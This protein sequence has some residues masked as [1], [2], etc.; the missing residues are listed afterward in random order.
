M[1][2]SAFPTLTTAP[3]ESN[4][5]QKRMESRSRKELL[6]TLLKDAA[7]ADIVQADEVGEAPQNAEVVIDEKDEKILHLEAEM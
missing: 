5:R 1:L 4:E 6:N 3:A 2:P 7:A